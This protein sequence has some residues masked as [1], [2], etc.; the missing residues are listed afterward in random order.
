MRPTP[1]AD[2]GVAVWMLEINERLSPNWDE[3]PNPKIDTVVLHYTGM[4]SGQEALTRM[5]DPAAKVS[6]HYMIEED[7]SLFRLVPEEKRAWHAG[8]SAWQGQENLNHNSIGIELVNP[9]HE[10]GYRSFPKS[11]IDTLLKLLEGIEQRHNVP[12]ARYIGHSDIA[13]DRK[14]DPGE[15]FPWYLLSGHGFGVWSDVDG[16][17]ITAVLKKGDSGPKVLSLNKQLGMVGYDWPNNLIYDAN[18][19]RVILAFQA[20]WRPLCVTGCY[21]R[22]TAL[23]LDDIA[24]KIVQGGKDI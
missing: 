16:T 5:C 4:R 12:Q 9:G 18:L 3:R 17:D 22:G 11:Q 2:S 14:I 10:F 24:L 6:A 7:G 19:E 21:D 15:L 8:V 20:H 13:P 23:I 1:R